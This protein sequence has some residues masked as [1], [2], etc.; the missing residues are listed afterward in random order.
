MLYHILVRA[1]PTRQNGVP[2][3]PKRFTFPHRARCWFY[4]G[5]AVE[6]GWTFLC[7]A[8]QVDPLLASVRTTPTLRAYQYGRFQLYLSAPGNGSLWFGES[9]MYM[10]S[11]L[12]NFY[13]CGVTVEPLNSTTVRFAAVFVVLPVNSSQPTNVL[14]NAYH[15]TNPWIHTHTH[16]GVVPLLPEALRI[17]RCGEN[18]NLQTNCEPPVLATGWGRTE[19]ES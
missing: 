19:S 10:Y 2:Q 5:R 15:C 13:T 4:F 6:L 17:R 18:V 12:T 16:M 8:E 3:A 7:S 11:M 14:V 1:S 9:E